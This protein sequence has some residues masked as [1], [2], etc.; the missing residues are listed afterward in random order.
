MRE[1]IVDEWI[2]LDGIVQGPSSPDEDPG[3]GF[4][5]GGWHVPYFDER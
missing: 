2:T 3:G 5:H 4:E 1:L